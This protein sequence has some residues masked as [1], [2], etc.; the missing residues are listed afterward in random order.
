[1]RIRK[2]AQRKRLSKGEWVRRAIEE[3]LERS[4]GGKLA[5]DPLS[6]LARLQAPTGDIASMLEEIEAGRA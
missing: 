6:E 4:G 1:V 3:A 5:T 2:A